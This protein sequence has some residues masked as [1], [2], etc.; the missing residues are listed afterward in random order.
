M[1]CEEK[2]TEII[3]SSE[4]KV[5]IIENLK[6]SENFTFL[7]AGNNRIVSKPTNKSVAYKIEEI[8]NQNKT[9]FK[10]YN[11]NSFQKWLLPVS[12]SDKDYTWIK[13]PIA[14]FSVSEERKV[15]FLNN[16]ID[17]HGIIPKDFSSD[18]IGT[19]DGRVVITDYGY[20]FR[21]Y[22]KEIQGISE[23]ES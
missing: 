20:G 1:N 19:V 13:C 8:P 23:I 3:R 18:D 6:A 10:I 21:D 2:L 17:N 4:L 9:E 22:E 16:L 14:K 15:E 12:K 5:D 7:N 11:N